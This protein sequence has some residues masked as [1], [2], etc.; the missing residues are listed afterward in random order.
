MFKDLEGMLVAR[1]LCVD[2]AR[3]MIATWRDS[4]FEEGS[5]LLYILPAQAVN[6]VLPLSV[7]PL[8]SSMV[9]VFVGRLELL[10]PAT[11]A[12][13]GQAFAGHHER[14]LDKYRRFLEPILRAMMAGAKADPARLQAL[15]ADLDSVYSDA[16][17]W[18]W[19]GD[20]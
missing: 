13:V 9:R 19:P 14:T 3:A 4:W 17:R 11:E 6:A 18:P 15:Q 7:N 5:R 10:T 8:P 1:G 16:C 20:R 12:A 2:E